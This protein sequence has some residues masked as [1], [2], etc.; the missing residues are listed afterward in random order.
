[1]TLAKEIEELL[2]DELSLESIKTVIDMTEFLK[3]KESQEIWNRIDKSETEYIS[4]EE[5][6]RI[7]KI[8]LNGEFISKDDVLAELGIK[9]DEI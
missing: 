8:K 6:S 2:K 9:K 7:E 1:M 3:F 4:E 5:N